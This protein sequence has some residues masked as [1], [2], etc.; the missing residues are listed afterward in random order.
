MKIK[1]LLPEILALQEE[2]AEN[3]LWHILQHESYT[4]GFM[5]YSYPIKFNM[6]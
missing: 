1:P 4:I 5:F 6:N 2:Q 3:I